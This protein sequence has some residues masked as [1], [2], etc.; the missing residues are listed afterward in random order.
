MVFYAVNSPALLLPRLLGRKIAINTDGLEWKRGMWGPVGRRYYK[1]AEWLSCKL[2]NR[3]VTDSIGI[4]NYY[5]EQYGVE[6]AHISYGAYIDKSR[7]PALLDS[8][9]ISPGEYFLQVTRFEPEN[10][11]LL[12]IQAF[13]R[14]NT[15]KKLVVVGGV[16]YDSPYSRAIAAEADERVILP[17]YVYGRDLLNELWCNC[18]AYVHGNE[19]GGTNPALLQ[20][21]ASGCFT[22]AID[23]PFSHDVLLDAG[24]YFEKS[25]EDLAAR[26]QWALD[27]A[28]ELIYFK[29]KAVERIMAQYS[30]DLVTDEYEALFRELI[31]DRR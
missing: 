16:P 1:L 3:I 19:V 8:L 28:E 14:L 15:T 10:N 18:F 9:G 5:R 7:I 22:I 23:V 12:T 17:G 29:V 13:K 20:T 25:Q 21:M 6:G 11:P 4:Q 31:A 26:M 2:A 30:W 24:I 27:H